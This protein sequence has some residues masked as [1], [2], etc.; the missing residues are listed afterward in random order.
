[1]FEKD[2]ES[3]KISVLE[4]SCPPHSPPPTFFFFFNFH[5][6]LATDLLLPSCIC[7]SRRVL[8]ASSGGSLVLQYVFLSD[9]WVSGKVKQLVEVAAGEVACDSTKPQ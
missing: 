4:M 6:L 5:I 8:I 3:S 2:L 9:R 1:M 7:R